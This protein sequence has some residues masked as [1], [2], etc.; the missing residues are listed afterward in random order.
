VIVE[1]EIVSGELVL[2]DESEEMRF[3][4]RGGFPSE[5]CPPAIKPIE[6][7]LNGATAVLR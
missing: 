5:I 6:D 4:E 1:A 7:Y 2:S 3:F